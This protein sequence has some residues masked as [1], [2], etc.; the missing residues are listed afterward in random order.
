VSA[1]AAPA[2]WNSAISE[3]KITPIAMPHYKT[4]SVDNNWY[5]EKP[6][7]GR[8]SWARCSSGIYTDSNGMRF[9]K[10]YYGTN[11]PRWDSAYNGNPG[12]TAW[13]GKEWNSIP[14]ETQKLNGY[15][16]IPIASSGTCCAS[17]RRIC[18]IDQSVYVPTVDKQTSFFF[19][20]NIVSH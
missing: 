2:V 12:G 5:F 9:N 7:K 19:K 10:P 6:Y 14:A 18:T 11:V 17:L 1:C 20:K 4:V 8:M 13:R 16:G 3:C 15:N